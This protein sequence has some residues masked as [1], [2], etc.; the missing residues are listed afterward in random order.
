M[1]DAT[2]PQYLDRRL[3]STTWF[4][5]MSLVRSETTTASYRSGTE[6]AAERRFDSN[7]LLHSHKDTIT[8]ISERVDTL[9]ESANTLPQPKSLMRK[10]RSSSWHRRRGVRAVL[11]RQP[12]G[13]T[14]MAESGGG[15]R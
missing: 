13:Q 9:V 15:R 12:Q 10:G 4:H 5:T 2:A 6:Y 7:S 14:A 11:R 1:F 8:F 3:M